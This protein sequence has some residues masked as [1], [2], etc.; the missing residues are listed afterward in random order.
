[1]VAA[2]GARL[3][4]VVE[5]RL[6][7]ARGFQHR[8]GVGEVAAHLAHAQGFQR[9]VVA[10]IETGDLM[11]ALDQAAAQGL[12]EETAAA[13]DQ[14]LHRV[15]PNR[16]A[17]HLASCSRWILALWRMSTGKPG[18]R[19]KVEIW[20]VWG[21]SFAI[22]WSCSKSCRGFRRSHKVGSM[23]TTGVCAP[24]GPMP[25]RAARATAGCAANTGSTC[26]V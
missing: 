8:V 21:C 10:A 14:N 26:S 2:P 9:R 1:V 5:D 12:A 17:A 23:Q 19:R 3:R 20:W 4:R 7:A 6:A 25:T 22:C 18:W 11:P 15:C 13:G 24:R 16:F